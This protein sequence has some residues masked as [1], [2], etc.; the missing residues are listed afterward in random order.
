MPQPPPIGQRHPQSP[1]SEDDVAVLCSAHNKRSQAR[2]AS[3]IETYGATDGPST[4]CCK[5]ITP[6][7]GKGKMPCTSGNWATTACMLGV[8]MEAREK[9]SALCS[10]DSAGSTGNAGSTGST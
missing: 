6:W 8:L 5:R 9:A 3:A 4:P 1:N 7:P 2:L 10:A